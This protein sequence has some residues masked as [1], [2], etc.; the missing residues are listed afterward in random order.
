MSFCAVPTAP[1]QCRFLFSSFY[2][3][4]AMP[5][6][7]RAMMAFMPRF[8]KHLAFTAKVLDGDSS[9]LHAQV[10]PALPVCKPRRHQ[11]LTNPSFKMNGHGGPSACIYDAKLAA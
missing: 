3:K 6:A 5:W 4:S 7:L 9:I 8:H 11:L 10:C 1:G 2:P